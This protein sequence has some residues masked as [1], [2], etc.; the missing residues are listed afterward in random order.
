VDSF[1]MD[2]ATNNRHMSCAIHSQMPKWVPVKVFIAK[3]L[4]VFIAST[5]TQHQHTIQ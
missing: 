3:F 5:S 1:V 2:Y 4:H